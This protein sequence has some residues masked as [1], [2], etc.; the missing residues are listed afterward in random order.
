MLSNVPARPL[1][2][3]NPTDEPILCNYQKHGTNAV[4]HL[5]NVAKHGN[6][7]KAYTGLQ[8]CS[9]LSY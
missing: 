5:M 1:T 2:L 8:N 7:H 4:A 3:I 9:G 6:E